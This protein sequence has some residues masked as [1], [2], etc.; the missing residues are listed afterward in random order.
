MLSVAEVQTTVQM[1]TPKGLYG[2]LFNPNGKDIYFHL[3]VFD[4]GSYVGE[5]PT[6][7]IIGERVEVVLDQ[8]K[9]V[10]CSRIDAPIER[11]GVVDWFDAEKGYGFAVCEER[12]V[13]LHRSEVQEGRLPLKGRRVSFYMCENGEESVRAC[14]VSVLSD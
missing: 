6:P 14:H 10:Q 8:G 9:V 11:F 12:Q 7:P 1:Y 4:P 2:F 13:F 5:A 3:S